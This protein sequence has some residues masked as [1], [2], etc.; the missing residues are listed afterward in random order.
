MKYPELYLIRQVN[1]A[2]A[3]V[4]HVRE[5]IFKKLRKFHVDQER[6]K[7]K[8][9][10]I[11]AGSRGIDRIPEVMRAVVDYVKMQGGTPVVFAAM[12]SHGNGTA[13]GQREMLAS[14]G[15]IEGT[16]E[17]EVLCCDTCRLLGKSRLGYEVYCNELADTFDGLILLNR[18]KTHTDFSDVTESGLLKMLAIGI[19][20]PQGC[21]G[22]HNRALRI[23]YGTAIRDTAELMLEKLPVLFGIMVTENWK[24]E[25]DSIRAAYPDQIL[26]EEKE[27]LRYVKDHQVKLPVDAADVL[28]VGEIGKNISGSGMDTKVIGLSLIHI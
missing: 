1:P 17:A 11:T 12:G 27:A 9:I 5:T 15:I 2:P 18:V 13:A 21:K 10:G 3:P 7:G 14:L 20:N 24:G 4:L 19:G 6:I 26:E 16:M 22:V 28:L 23:G 25:L 8:R